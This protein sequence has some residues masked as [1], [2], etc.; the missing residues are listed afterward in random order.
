MTE[1]QMLLALGYKPKPRKSGLAS[2]PL[3]TRSPVMTHD[4]EAG[5][6]VFVRDEYGRTIPDTSKSA[7]SKP[8][9]EPAHD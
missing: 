9:K 7:F 6:M 5:G 3:G 1:A 8:L 2:P 4:S